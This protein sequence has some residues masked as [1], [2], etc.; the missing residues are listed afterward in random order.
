MPVLMKPSTVLEITRGH[1]DAWLFANPVNEVVCPGYFSIVKEPMD[2]S[3]IA[4]RVE[5]G[6]YTSK[7]AFVKDFKR[8]VENCAFYNGLQS[9]VA[10]KGYRLWMAML[11]TLHT[12]QG[13]DD[14]SGSARLYVPGSIGT[15]KTKMPTSK[16]TT[17]QESNNQSDL[18]EQ[19]APKSIRVQKRRS[20]SIQRERRRK[21]TM[22]MQ[23]QDDTS[24]SDQLYVPR[25]V[26]LSTSEPLKRH[27]RSSRGKACQDSD[28][29]DLDPV[30]ANVPVAQTQSE[31]IQ[32]QSKATHQESDT[33]NLHRLY[34]PASILITR[35]Q[36]KPIQREPKGT[37]QNGYASNPDRLDVPIARTQ[38][39]PSH[40]RSKREEAHVPKEQNETVVKRK[41][42]RPPKS[43]SRSILK[44][45]PPKDPA[46]EALSSAT[47]KALED[48]ADLTYDICRLDGSLE[49]S[50]DVVGY[51]PDLK[52]GGTQSHPSE[53]ISKLHD[54][55]GRSEGYTIA[56]G[57]QTANNSSHAEAYDQ[58]VDKI[59]ILEHGANVQPDVENAAQ[60]TEA[61]DEEHRTN[62]I[63]EPTVSTVC[64]T[65][66]KNDSTDST[67]E[68]HSESDETGRRP[69]TEI[70]PDSPEIAAVP[71]A[72]GG[73][74]AVECD[75]GEEGYSVQM[76]SRLDQFAELAPK[77]DGD[78]IEGGFGALD[79]IQVRCKSV[80]PLKYAGQTLGQLLD[81]AP[82]DSGLRERENREACPEYRNDESAAS[83]VAD[84]ET[85][86]AERHH[87]PIL[88]HQV[89]QIPDVFLDSPDTRA[90]EP[91]PKDPESVES[92]EP[93]ERNG[94]VL[95]DDAGAQSEGKEER[96][97][98]SPKLPADLQSLEKE[99]LYCVDS[100]KSSFSFSSGYLSEDAAL[101]PTRYH[102]NSP[103]PQLSPSRLSPLPPTGATSL[104]RMCELVAEIPAPPTIPGRLPSVAATCGR[105]D[106]PVLKPAPE[107]RPH[108][109][110]RSV[111]P[112]VQAAVPR[113]IPPHDARSFFVPSANSVP[114]L[115][116]AV[117]FP[118]STAFSNGAPMFYSL[119][120]A[121]W[122]DA[123]SHV[124]WSYPSLVC[125]QGGAAS[126]GY[127]VPQ[128][129]P[130][131]LLDAPWLRRPWQQAVFQGFQNGPTSLHPVGASPSV[132]P[133]Q[134]WVGAPS[135]GHEY[136]PQ[137]AL[138][139][140]PTAFR[141]HC[142]EQQRANFLVVTASKQGSIP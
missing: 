8:M 111:Q 59:D 81:S 75:G 70:A 85:L 97:P 69:E 36:S 28:T 141:L 123:M 5:D 114:S 9:E 49:T 104:Q 73:D 3:L 83:E 11:D 124:Q 57:T 10:G 84:K 140:Q 119:S 71:D 80:P 142:P 42:G 74:N 94:I 87:N 110:C 6:L 48:S 50:S 134:V 25:F 72:K 53:L 2:L 29:S 15:S 82:F 52:I 116:S 64:G 108:P 121:P 34:V 23:G 86:S 43:V 67:T 39:K 27:L 138:S 38:F 91:E 30:S 58:L 122:N 92:P 102:G 65:D 128:A 35:T 137:Q 16:Q 117:A 60:T 126:R 12:V 26:R 118:A 96:L 115:T 89:E 76:S 54:A 40:R 1:K 103:L 112:T 63:G 21:R 19:Y 98:K 18:N 13:S 127:Y 22:R 125:Q 45:R 107:P 100:P 120:P 61:E 90:T 105:R 7:E 95:L 41:R 44:T 24:D 4:K 56:E 31:S 101:S 55:R 77:T 66:E 113:P 33:G 47:R 133:N 109:N 130:N 79:A 32:R 51:F 68:R 20:V 131:L 106:R 78:Y 132:A 37:R 17:E 139:S 99:G 14:A 46:M 136:H 88:V 135:Y 93:S 62:Q 129:A